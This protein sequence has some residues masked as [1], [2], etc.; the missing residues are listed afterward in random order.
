[1]E[2]ETLLF[3]FSVPLTGLPTSFFISFTIYVLGISSFVV[4]IFISIPF[5]YRCFF[6]SIKNYISVLQFNPD[7]K[8]RS[9]LTYLIFSF[10]VLLLIVFPYDFFNYLIEN[11]LIFFISHIISFI[12]IFLY[13]YKQSKKIIFVSKKIVFKIL[14][15]SLLLLNLY[16]NFLVLL[17]ILFYFTCSAFLES[18]Y[19]KIQPHKWCITYIFIFSNIY[20]LTYLIKIGITYK[21]LSWQ[22]IYYNISDI[23]TYFVFYILF[24][25]A[26]LFFF[27]SKQ[28]YSKKS[29]YI[30]LLMISYIA[31]LQTLWNFEQRYSICRFIKYEYFSEPSIVY[32]KYYVS[33]KNSKI[34]PPPKEQNLI[35]LIL[36]SMEFTFSNLENYISKRETKEEYNWI[37]ELSMLASENVSFTNFRN[38][39][40]MDYSIGSVVAMM[41]GVPKKNMYDNIYSL[42]KIL[43]SN[44]YTNFVFEGADIA[45]GYLDL[46]LNANGFEGH[47]YGKNSLKNNPIVLNSKSKPWDTERGKWGIHDRDLFAIC[48]EKFPKYFQHQPFFGIIITS[49]THFATDE[50]EEIIELNY[51][52]A[53]QLVYDFVTW[54]QRS[55][56]GNNTTIIIVGDHVR[57][58]N[59]LMEI[60][61]E[62]RNIYNVFINP[63]IKPFEKNRKFWS[64][65]M[66]P[67]ILESIGFKIQGHR[68]GL[69][70][71]V[72]SKEP[73][74]LECIGDENLRNELRKRN[75]YHH[76][77]QKT[78]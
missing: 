51:R 26:L 41:Y 74:L 21:R 2:L 59:F 77:N 3:F 62:T 58:G 69:G 43:K 6:P 13:F 24:Y 22:F 65:D 70:T 46:F 57:M 35:L 1:M 18:K 66:L 64:M 73:T 55:P 11:L 47:I 52:E 29:Y 54:V 37:P 5:F 48:K 10:I 72:F 23:F 44:N 76:T 63:K 67:T 27:S 75:Q 56:V 38:G 31:I 14:L 71:S 25:I 9:L 16:I 15:S 39:Y 60:P 40:C 53:S 34:I 33:S 61:T 30:F 19:K 7:Y 28:E 8:I 49:Y 12:L 20:V 45:Y 68:L 50:T 17:C 36:E 78:H 4:L 32:E 42:G